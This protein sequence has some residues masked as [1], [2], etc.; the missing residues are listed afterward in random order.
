MGIDQKGG[1]GDFLKRSVAGASKAFRGA[2]MN[3]E[4]PAV[5][6]A[7]SPI[8]SL[9]AE[10]EFAERVSLSGI[11]PYESFDPE[12]NI[13]YCRDRVGF[14]LNCSPA[15]GLD[16]SKLQVLNGLMS[17]ASDADTD[18]QIS[19]MADS[20]VD[21]ILD[22]WHAEKLHCD[23]GEISNVFDMLSK[24]RVDYL[25]GGNWGSLFDQQNFL[26]R[27]YRLVI[28]FSVPSPLGMKKHDADKETI[29]FLSRTQ[30]SFLGVLRS[31]GIGAGILSP[32]DLINL[33]NSFINPSRGE[34][35]P[36]IKY[37]ENR[38]ISEQI[39]DEDTALLVNSGAMSIVHKGQ[40][41]SVI[42][43]HVRQYPEAWAGW[44]NGELIGSFTNDILRLGCPFILTL[45][46]NIPDQ[47]SAKS[48]VKQKNMRATQMADSPIAKY[49]TQWNDRKKDWQFVQ[50]QVD[51][52]GMFVNAFY[53]ITL[54]TKPEEEQACEQAL[55]AVYNTKG[56]ILSKSRYIPTHAFLGALPMGLS[57]EGS[58]NLK[59]FN[60]Y[61]KMLSWNCTNIAPWIAEWKGNNNPVLMFLGRRG[62][63]TYVDPF[64]NKKG[65]FNIACTAASG[66]G[67]SYFT[68]EWIFS[69]L[70]GG[71][72]AFVIDAGH[73]Y[74]NI[75][76]LLG[77]AYLEFG[78]P[79]VNICLN[80]FSDI[81]EDNPE[82]FADQIPLLKQLI[83]QMAGQKNKLNQKQSSV[84]EK[85]I[86]AAWKKKASSAT[87][88]TVVEC[89][90][91][92]DDETDRLYQTAQD[93]AT[94]L[95]SYTASGMYAKY[96]E[97]KANIDLGNRFIVLE[98]DA[99]NQMPELQSVVLLI[100]M[101]RI[102]QVMYLAGNK[103]QRKLCIIDEAW[104]LL[105]AGGNAGDFINEGYRVARKHGGSFMTITQ[106]ISDYY[107]SD[108]AQ[109]A[110]MNS[111]FEISLR[112]K[113]SELKQAET[114]GYIDNSTGKVDLLKSLDTVGGMYSELAID[115]PNGISVCRFVVDPVTDKIYSTK[116]EDVQFIREKEKEGYSLLDAVGLLLEREG[117]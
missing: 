24:K 15:T 81:R 104:R 47:V 117:G 91:E 101:M 106:K 50:K 113:A 107:Q 12:N 16:K 82:Y 62:Q 98:L 49:A 27:N 8:P 112:Q 42:S 38:S 116:A 111:D 63:L 22:N 74:K 65:N 29:G 83:S 5:Q 31:A 3:D 18:I 35:Q 93:L 108:T 78:N 97:G 28:S 61:R 84:L 115:T 66:G 90:Q 17:T 103:S 68:Q 14:M 43:Y 2:L 60:H 59:T 33:L 36:F 57:Q 85:A 105:N 77:G 71:G 20:N 19:L 55:Q 9:A 100:L 58:K 64:E 41:T 54:F 79:D 48:G 7:N 10:K 96:F 80:P 1:L 69:I 110:L 92:D 4:A 76:N 45:N 114:K 72:R 95:H 37:D 102:T 86:M 70:G 44:N 34:K 53:Q 109:A 88:T 25:R 32:Q 51:G 94:M 26:V 75:C 89:L 23:D 46:V 87:I 13:Y 21:R 39:V 11:L 67:K 99:L 56:W 30:K 40:P 6:F 52:G 73:S